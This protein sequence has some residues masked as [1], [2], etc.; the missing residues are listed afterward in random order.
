MNIEDYRRLSDG[1]QGY[2]EPEFEDVTFLKIESY[3][4]HE[5]V[6]QAAKEELRV[7][8]R[9]KHRVLWNGTN[10]TDLQRK[11]ISDLATDYNAKVRIVYIDCSVEQAIVQNRQREEN[12]QVKNEVIERYSRKMDIPSIIECH[13][14]LVIK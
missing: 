13:E 3:S 12:K 7:N 9:K 14:L 2:R 6:Y 10:M 1:D 8:L 4:N 5:E 11:T